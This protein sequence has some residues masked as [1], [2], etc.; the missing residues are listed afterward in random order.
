ML[1]ESQLRAKALD[2]PRPRLEHFPAPQLS[3]PLGNRA[4]VAR[5]IDCLNENAIDTG[6]DCDRC[7]RAEE[8]SGGP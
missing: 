4:H 6:I 5:L 8:D 1:S 7:S 2:T 3:T